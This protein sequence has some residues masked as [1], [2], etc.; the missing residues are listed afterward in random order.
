MNIKKRFI[1]SVI[2]S[3]GK[4]EVDLPWTRGQ[5][6]RAFI[7]KREAQARLLKRSA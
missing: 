4:Q 7:A 1:Q 3:A 6:R 5:R 2:S